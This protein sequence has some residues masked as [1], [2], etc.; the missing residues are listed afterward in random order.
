MKRKDLNLGVLVLRAS[1]GI[2]CNH[3]PQQLDRIER[4][5]GEIHSGA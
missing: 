5:R 2:L 4:A 3:T 1:L